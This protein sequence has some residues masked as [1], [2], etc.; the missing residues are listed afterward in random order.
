[1][2]PPDLA[3]SLPGHYAQWIKLSGDKIFKIT[4]ILKNYPESR[5]GLALERRWFIYPLCV[6][7]NIPNLPHDIAENLPGS[8]TEFLDNGCKTI[9]EVRK[10]IVDAYLKNSPDT[11]LLVFL[12]PSMHL[13]G[14]NSPTQ[15]DIL[16]IVEES[17]GRSPSTGFKLP[18]LPVGM[19]SI[20]LSPLPIAL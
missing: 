3:E 2:Q 20:E 4:N 9:P 12:T 10:R 18:T 11:G 16:V 15:K 17:N 14:I 6:N 5:A 13:L 1:M 8:L 7:L 19:E